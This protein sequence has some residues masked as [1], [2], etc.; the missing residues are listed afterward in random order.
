MLDSGFT[1]QK[2]RIFLS[3]PGKKRRFAG[4]SRREFLQYSQAAALAFLPA[5]L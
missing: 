2:W 5:G 3:W 4:L 1:P